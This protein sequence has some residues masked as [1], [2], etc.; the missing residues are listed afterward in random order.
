MIKSHHC[1]AKLYATPVT[2][3]PPKTHPSYTPIQVFSKICRKLVNAVVFPKKDDIHNISSWELRAVDSRCTLFVK[4]AFWPLLCGQ[5][6]S[7]FTT[8]YNVPNQHPE[9]NTTHGRHPQKDQTSRNR[10]RTHVHIHNTK[11]PSHAHE[12][13]NHPHRTYHPRFL[14]YSRQRPSC[15]RLAASVSPSR[16]NG[17]LNLTRDTLSGINVNYCVATLV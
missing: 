2:Q 1:D 14:P 17:G 8:A 11:Q 12:L 6:L 16:T 15:K 13:E 10:R 9:H 7:I 3:R 4:L 5:K